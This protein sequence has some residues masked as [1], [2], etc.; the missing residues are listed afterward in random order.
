MRLILL[1]VSAGMCLAFTPLQTNVIRASLANYTP[2]EFVTIVD[3]PLRL[4]FGFTEADRTH[5]YIDGGKL[6]C[7]PN[8]FANVVH[9]ELDH[10]K[11]RDHNSIPGDIMSYRVT[12]DASGRTVEDP[13]VW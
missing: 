3:A 2:P 11:G 8:A 6:K 7:C 1:V 9:H 13:V 12:V 5:V 4:D 10:T